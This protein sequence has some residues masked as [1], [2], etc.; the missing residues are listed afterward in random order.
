MQLEAIKVY[1]V[2][3]NYGDSDMSFIVDKLYQRIEDA[4]EN[5][6][7]DERIEEMEVLCRSH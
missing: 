6:E 5:L 2:G 3:H 1:A 7:S 4:Q